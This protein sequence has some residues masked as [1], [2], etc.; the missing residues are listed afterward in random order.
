[1]IETQGMA[2]Y[3]PVTLPGYKFYSALVLFIACNA[4]PGFRP[5][6]GE[7]DPASISVIRSEAGQNR[8]GELVAAYRAYQDGNLEAAR[9][10]YAQ[11]LQTYPDNRDAMLGLA[12]CAVRQGD[13]KSAV[14]MYQRII[15]AFP[16][17][18]LSRAALIGL[19]RNRQG[20][21]V[22]MELLSKQP[23]N[24]FLHSVMGR[25][26]AEQARWAEA[27]Q[28]FSAAHRIDPAN[29]VYLLN[30]AISLDRLGQREEALGY[31]RATLKLV[32]QDASDLDIRPVLKRIQSLRRP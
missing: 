11:V 18:A 17:D 4:F 26:L 31:Y 32:Q 5:V 29:P 27:R 8:D 20:G 14:T 10:G 12:A 25:I 1:M 6:W 13:V 30:L 9:S 28:A 2:G 3:A 21:P 22:I 19:Q 15:H 7:A 23:D 16:Q 24:P